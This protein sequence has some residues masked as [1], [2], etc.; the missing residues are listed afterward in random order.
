MIKRDARFVWIVPSLLA[1]AVMACAVGGGAEATATPLPR[2]TQRPLATSTTEPAT[3]KPTARPSAT[4]AAAK[5]TATEQAQ[6]TQAA[7]EVPTDTGTGNSTSAPPFTLSSKPYVHKSG[8]FTVNLPDGWTVQDGDNSVFADSPDKVASIDITFTNVGAKLD[9]STLDILIKAEENN[10]FGTYKDYTAKPE[11]KQSDGS[12]LIFKTLSLSDGTAESVFSYYWEDGNVVYEQDF[13]VDSDSYDQ[14]ASGLVSVANSMKT[15][16]AAGA[17]ANAYAVVYTFTDT[18]NLFQF[19]VPYGWT[20][21]TS[22]D[23]NSNVETFTSPDKLSYVEN[24]AYDDGTTISK[25]D[26]GAFALDLLKQY[27]KVTDLKVTDDKP[28]S[29]GSERLT[30]NSAS[31]NLDGESFFETR[32]TTFLLLTWVVDTNQYD[33]F[34]PV[35][36]KVVSS[37]K[38]PQP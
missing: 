22:T 14:Y 25:S 7:T 16:S 18:N 20:H 35:W 26:A 6:T 1:L 8:A 24:I 19:D 11:E 27:Y 28:Q 21:D 2:P 5:P 34:K 4:K 3:A 30:W 38:V 15:D 37:Y 9:A 33:F 17:K 10:W 32:G 12:L 36:T 31:Q 13:W 29:D 23:T